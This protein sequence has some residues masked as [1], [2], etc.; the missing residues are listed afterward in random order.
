[1]TAPI[2]P[3]CATAA[4][5]TTGAAVYPNRPDLAAKPIWR[6]EGCGAYVAC[7]P[8]TTVPL[9]TPA[10]AATR[11]A[12]MN[13][14]QKRLDPLWKEAWREPAYAKNGC[15]PKTRRSIQ[16]A[17]RERVYAYLAG[18]MRLTPAECH[19]GLFTREQ[20][21]VAWGVLSA[22]SYAEI[23]TWARALNPKPRRER[24]AP[25]PSSDIQRIAR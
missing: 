9:G 17:A 16:K 1:M 21:R 4:V 8:D 5:L 13:L 20:C 15:G 22:T 14:H 12:R 2:C 19:T 3:T 7:H 10:D 18:R 6:C 25:S 11:A 24:K 23:R